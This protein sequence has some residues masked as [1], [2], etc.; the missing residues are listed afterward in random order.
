[1]NA[2]GLLCI[3]CFRQIKM[4][5]I[6]SAGRRGSED[7]Y[8]YTPVNCCCRKSYGRLEQFDPENKIRRSCHF[9]DGNSVTQVSA[10]FF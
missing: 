7:C 1:M 6:Q 3:V 5:L 4:L 8:R 9:V 10:L 2:E